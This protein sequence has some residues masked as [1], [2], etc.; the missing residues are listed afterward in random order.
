ML[1]CEKA[2]RSTEAASQGRHALQPESDL[3]YTVVRK[4]WVMRLTPKIPATVDSFYLAHAVVGAFFV[5]PERYF[6]SHSQVQTTWKEGET[7]C[8]EEKR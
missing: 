6:R 3:C 4:E 7:R 2:G 5:S 8:K 1:A